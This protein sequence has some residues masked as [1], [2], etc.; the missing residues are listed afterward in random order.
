MNTQRKLPFIGALGVVF[1]FV[2]IYGLFDSYSPSY[3][4]TGPIYG[5]VV[6]KETGEP[7]EGAVAVIQFTLEGG[8]GNFHGTRSQAI[9]LDESVTDAQGRYYFPAWRAEHVKGMAAKKYTPGISVV[10]RGYKIG[11]V[12][13]DGGPN[14]RDFKFAGNN[15]VVEL[16][17]YKSPQDE[18]YAIEYLGQSWGAGIGVKCSYEK[19]TKRIAESFARTKGLI[20]YHPKGKTTIRSSDGDLKSWVQRLSSRGD[21]KKDGCKDPLFVFRKYI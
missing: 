20:P 14:E 2:L 6:D 18:I 1:L 21:W 7:I 11:S 12:R 4:A 10:R 15:A 17:A 5:T 16:E 9:H 19:K 8:A 3:Y 13:H